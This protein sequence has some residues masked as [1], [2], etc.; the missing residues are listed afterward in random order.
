M[1]RDKR[2]Y[3]AFTQALRAQQ[4]TPARPDIVGYSRT[5]SEIH[6]LNVT[7]TQ[8]LRAMTKN[9][10]I[11][12]PAGPLFPAEILAIDK[13]NDELAELDADI[14]ASMKTTAMP[15]PKTRKEAAHA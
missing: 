2:H 9:Y 11:P 15:R 4:D 5:V 1:L 7:V 8:L 10:S 3:P 6:K 13:A 12:F 14:A